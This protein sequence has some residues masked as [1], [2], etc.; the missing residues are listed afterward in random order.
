MN[1][2]DSLQQAEP[3]LV[4]QDQFGRS[5]RKLRISV[6]DRCNFKCVYCMPEHP[7]WMKKHD[8]LSF[9]ELYHFCEFMVHRGIEQIRITGG[10]PLM[11]QGV[12]HFIAELQLLKK[13]GLKRISMTTNGHYLKQYAA[14]LKQA[15]LDDLNI[16]LDSLDADQ[17]EQLTAKKLQPVLEGI[18][19]AQ[20]AGLSI[21]INTVL[22]KGIN[23]TQ[24]LPLAHWAK[25]ENIELRFIEFMPLDGDQN[26]SRD[27]VVSE[28]DILEQLATEFELK[29]GQSQGA[30]PARTYFIEGM[31]IGIIS[32]ITHSFCGSCDR[33]RLNAQGEFFN[34]L[35]STQGLKLKDRIQQLQQQAS[36][37]EHMLQQ[38]L[39]PYIWNKAAGFHAIQMQQKQLNPAP[40]TNPNF[41][42]IS[43]HM[44]GG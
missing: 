35:F 38:Q 18:Q 14:A 33:L 10:E 13:N 15:G 19:A 1:Y 32:T 17:F 2:I 5:K 21:K 28:Q 6:T 20:Q 42:K 12:V 40:K 31:P 3:V 37:A 36:S 4:F 16:S 25:R 30:N 24:I 26:W 34:C 43:M 23:E 22:I 9:E 11:R 44:I 39:S 8:L 29:I 41:R 27:H 7:E